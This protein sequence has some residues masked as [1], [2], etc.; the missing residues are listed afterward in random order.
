M[1]RIKNGLLTVLIS[2]FLAVAHTAP[3]FAAAGAGFV[4]K[5][6]LPENQRPEVAAYFDLNVQPG[7]TQE[8]SV[9]VSNESGQP[10]TVDAGVGVATTNRSGDVVYVSAESLSRTPK[11]LI[12]DMLDISQSRVEIPANAERDIVFTLAVP[13]EAFDGIVIGS[14]R[15]LKVLTEAEAQ[16]AGIVNQYAYS[17]PI[18]LR[19]NEEEIAPDFYLESVEAQLVNYSASVVCNIVNPQPKLI[20]DMSITAEI[21]AQ[22]ADTPILEFQ[23]E[24][25]SMAPESVLPL[26]LQEQMGNGFEGGQYTARINMQYEGAEWSFEEPFEITVEQAE[27]SVREELQSSPENGQPVWATVLIVVVIVLIVAVIVA[28]VVITKRMNDY[29]AMLAEAK[30][31]KQPEALPTAEEENEESGTESK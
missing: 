24:R 15:V 31:S 19:Q 29:R 6:N 14:I 10:I 16:T 25:V 13:E 1:R 27:T 2:A 30:N 12:S 26:T 7:Q 21:Y 9:L 4:V 18:R 22:G 20:R 11:N 8:L 3:A 17:I 28:G 23:S 5:P